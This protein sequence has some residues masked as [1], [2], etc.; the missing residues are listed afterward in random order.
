MSTRKAQEKKRVMTLFSCAFVV[1][2]KINFIINSGKE[3]ESVLTLLVNGP[4][5][6]HETIFLGHL[7]GGTFV[8]A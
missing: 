2:L 4:S 3:D 5:V 8:F 1:K 6:E 7:A